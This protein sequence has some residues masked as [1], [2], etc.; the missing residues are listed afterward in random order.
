MDN[1]NIRKIL[2]HEIKILNIKI[3]ERDKQNQNKDNSQPMLQPNIPHTRDNCRMLA[4]YVLLNKTTESLMCSLAT[5]YE[6]EMEDNQELFYDRCIA[7]KMETEQDLKDV[8]AAH[9]LN[10]APSDDEMLESFD[11]YRVD[12]KGRPV[13]KNRIDSFRIPPPPTS[14]YDEE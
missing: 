2:E 5:R 12:K 8:I 1:D 11:I 7:Q 14:Y 10:I 9:R 6:H 13:S 4:Y 3:R